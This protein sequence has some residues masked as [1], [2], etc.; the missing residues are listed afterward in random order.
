MLAEYARYCD[1]NLPRQAQGYMVMSFKLNIASSLSNIVCIPMLA[2]SKVESHQKLWT[3]ALTV[4]LVRTY[5]IHVAVDMYTI[6]LDQII[7]WK[8]HWVKS[9]NLTGLTLGDGSDGK[10]KQESEIWG[11]T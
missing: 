5:R 3:L 7:G 9:S 8:I 1:C 6:Y 11:G 2:M 10:E 4:I